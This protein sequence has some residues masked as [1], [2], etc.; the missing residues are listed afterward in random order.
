MVKQ[1]ANPTYAP[2]AHPTSPFRTFEAYVC[3]YLLSRSGK[4]HL[5]SGLI[6]KLLPFLP[7]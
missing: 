3:S 7:R 5:F 2:I 6:Q 4:A 1:V